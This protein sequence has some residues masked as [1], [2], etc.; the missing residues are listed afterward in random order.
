MRMTL[1]K[2]AATACPFIATPEIFLTVPQNITRVAAD[3][4]HERIRRAQRLR[5]TSALFN[6]L[7]TLVN[8][9]NI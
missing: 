4:I 3:R 1:L 8:T 2:K 7:L 6:D 5:Q 9:N